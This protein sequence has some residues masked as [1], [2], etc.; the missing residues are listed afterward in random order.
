MGSQR[1]RHDWVTELN[2][3]HYKGCLVCFKHLR[4]LLELHL[5]KMSLMNPLVINK[6]IVEKWIQ[7]GKNRKQI[8]L[9]F[10]SNLPFSSQSPRLSTFFI[11][12]KKKKS[13]QSG[14]F[15]LYLGR[16]GKDKS[17]NSRWQTGCRLEVNASSKQIRRR[18]GLCFHEES[19]RL[20]LIYLPSLGRQNLLFLM[21]YWLHILEIELFLV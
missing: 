3:K 12:R 20:F 5:S 11:S 19:L 1:V 17:V 21:V 6:I 2:E 14:K 9:S 13:L 18:P 15:K 8:P 7:E 10:C 4:Q 16:I